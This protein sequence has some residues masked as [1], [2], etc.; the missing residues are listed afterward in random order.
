MKGGE[1][2]DIRNAILSAKK[3]QKGIT[4]KKWMPGP[5]L[6]IIPTNSPALCLMIPYEWNGA[7]GKR[8][9]PSFEDLVANDWFSI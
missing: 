3:T 7:I 8:W 6:R 1:V 9:E 5:K 2:M 4:R